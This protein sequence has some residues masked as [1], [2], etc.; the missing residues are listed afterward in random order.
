MRRF[1]SEQ[2]FTKFL[3]ELWRVK[4]RR[5]DNRAGTELINGEWSG[6]ERRTNSL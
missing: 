3:D 5:E 6:E 4:M 1:W 2:R